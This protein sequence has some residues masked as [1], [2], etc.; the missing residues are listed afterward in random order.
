MR[1]FLCRSLS[2][3]RF[4]IRRSEGVDYLV[5]AGPW[6][7]N[8]APINKIISEAEKEVRTRG[9][10]GGFHLHLNLTL[11]DMGFLLTQIGSSDIAGPKG[12]AQIYRINIFEIV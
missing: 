6:F 7:K 9:K 2:R 8:M 10:S 11:W 12:T 4:N 1:K 3:W 5:L